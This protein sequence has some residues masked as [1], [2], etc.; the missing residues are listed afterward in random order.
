MATII[1]Y[2]NKFEKYLKLRNNAPATIEM[3]CGIMK[4]WL[5]HFRKDPQSIT[6]DMIGDYI[7]TM[8]SSSMMR[9][10][11]YTLNNFYANVM[12]KKDY[13]EHIPV[14][15]REKYLPETFNALE[16]IRLI[17]A[18]ANIKHRAVLQL[19]Y[20]CGLRIGE[21]VAL[22]IVD[23]DGVRKQIHI[24]HSKGAKDRIIPI[25]EETLNLLRQYFTEYKPKVYLFEGQFGGQYTVRSIQ[26]VFHQAKAKA[27]IYK[28]VTVH[29][30]RHSRATHLLCNGVD[31]KFI[32]D[33]LGH[34][35]I[36]TTTDFYIHTD[37][38]DLQQ[39]IQ[40]ADMLFSMQHKL[41]AA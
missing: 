16:V 34:S 22:K 40:R 15:K 10:V 6:P 14:A 20:S 13:L 5:A 37:V 9:Q 32:A 12:L 30:L 7:L 38:T 26:Q 27:K 33:L 31:I 23:I 36:K 41:L 39:A 19:I 8:K 2:S 17:D 25:P 35:N 28:K 24:K 29:S 21:A 4:L 11:Y 18:T 3:Y 1:D